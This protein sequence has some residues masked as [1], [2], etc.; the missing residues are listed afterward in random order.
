MEIN[1]GSC[2]LDL[3]HGD[4]TQQSTDA[5]VNAANRQLAGGGGV[6]GAIHRGGGPSIMA[7]TREKYPQ[8]CPTGEAVIT[9][10][11]QLPARYV[12]HTVGPIWRG[13]KQGEPDL[14]ASAYRRSLEV[15]VDHHCQSVAFPS[16][17]TGAYGYPLDL[18]A[19]IALRTVMAFLQERQQPAWVRF[20]LFDQGTLDTF[21]QMLTGLQ[22]TQ[23][24]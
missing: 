24:A 22:A 14:L 23:E 9:G 7:E 5:M 4:I 11:G 12:I 16:L 21:V 2:K 17:S 1:I 8:G 10:A 15:A 20:V 19:R 18:A 13:G 3:V 6:D